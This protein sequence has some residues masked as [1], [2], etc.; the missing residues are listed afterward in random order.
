VINLRKELFKKITQPKKAV[1]IF[2]LF[3]LSINMCTSFNCSLVTSFGA[4]IIKSCALPL[5]G[6]AIISLIVSASVNIINI[7]SIPN[8]IPACGGAPNWNAVYKAPNY[9]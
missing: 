2:Y 1:H 9:F 6:N 5:R 4:P 3:L 7:L 8:A